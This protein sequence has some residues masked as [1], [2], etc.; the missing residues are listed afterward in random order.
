M[1]LLFFFF[2]SVWQFINSLFPLI[3]FL[4]SNRIINVTKKKQIN[5]T[6]VF[7]MHSH[8]II[9]YMK[10]FSPSCVDYFKMK[11]YII[12]LSSSFFFYIIIFLWFFLFYVCFILLVDVYPIVNLR[13]KLKETKKLKEKKTRYNLMTPASM[14]VSKK[15][16]GRARQLFCNEMKKQSCLRRC[17]KS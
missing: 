17:G 6:F 13:A 16:D 9:C 15:T 7:F 1:K 12:F 10:N 14:R 4:F 3:I 2:F 8:R 11:S 5:F